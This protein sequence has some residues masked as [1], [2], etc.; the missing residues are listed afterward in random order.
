M[1]AGYH[2]PGRLDFNVALGVD[3]R[4]V[5]SFRSVR[6]CNVPVGDRHAVAAQYRARSLRAYVSGEDRFFLRLQN[7]HAVGFDIDVLS[8]CRRILD[9]RR[10]YRLRLRISMPGDQE[11]CAQSPQKHPLA[12]NRFC[13]CSDPLRP[14][15]PN[16]ALTLLKNRIR[17]PSS[18]I[19]MP[20]DLM[21][22]L[23]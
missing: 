22:P 11:G 16:V 12:I 6:L 5:V 7:F 9:G 19:S 8:A 1:L 14:L 23:A 18:T 20:F 17:A 15:P 21:T 13:H 10:V 3:Q 2:L 4:H